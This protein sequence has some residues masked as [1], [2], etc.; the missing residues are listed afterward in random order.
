MKWTSWREWTWTFI[1]GECGSFFF[2]KFRISQRLYGWDDK[3]HFDFSRNKRRREMHGWMFFLLM[4]ECFDKSNAIFHSVLLSMRMIMESFYKNHL[5]KRKEKKKERKRTKEDS[6]IGI[7]I[8]CNKIETNGK[9]RMNR[10]KTGKQ[11]GTSSSN[12][13]QTMRQK[14]I[15]FFLSCSLFFLFD[16][17]WLWSV[18]A[19]KCELFWFGILFV[20]F[21]CDCALENFECEWQF[22]IAFRS[23]LIINLPTRFIL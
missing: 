7:H 1:N 21:E 2:T 22:R 6:A 11:T 12:N 4:W 20:G 17:W 15:E 14:C 18:C 9:E 10:N 5:N 3:Y 19:F 8:L 13:F 23:D 16:M